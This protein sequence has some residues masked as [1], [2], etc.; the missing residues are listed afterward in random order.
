MLQTLKETY[1]VAKVTDTDTHATRKTTPVSRICFALNNS[2]SSRP[3]APFK[4]AY[5]FRTY[6]TSEPRATPVATVLFRD[7]TS[8]HS[9]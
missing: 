2:K 4:L 9:R 6:A 1:H 7:A 3:K 5:I 8:C